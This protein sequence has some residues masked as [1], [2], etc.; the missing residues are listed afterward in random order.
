[1]GR[2]AY[3]SGDGSKT[4]FTI[5]LPPEC[6]SW[7]YDLAEKGDKSLTELVIGFVDDARTWWGL[8]EAVGNELRADAKALGLEQRDY[9][10]YLLTNRFL[11]TKQKGIGFDKDAPEVLLSRRR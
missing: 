9:V 10:L 2:K 4:A 1:M 8:S 11:V 3:K 7:M 5:R 6:G